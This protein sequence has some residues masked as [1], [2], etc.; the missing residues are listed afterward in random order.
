MDTQSMLSVFN[1]YHSLVFLSFTNKENEPQTLVQCLGNVSVVTIG[2]NITI[3][4]A[5]LASVSV[6][7][8]CV[9]YTKH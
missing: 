7:I 2:P 4:K 1:S 5:Y 3:Q 6:C 8:I 9:L